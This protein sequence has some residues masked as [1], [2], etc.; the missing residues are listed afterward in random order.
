VNCNE[1]RKSVKRDLKK[2]K[3]TTKEGRRQLDAE[4]DVLSCSGAR[5]QTITMLFSYQAQKDKT[6]TKRTGKD[7]SP[8]L[9]KKKTGM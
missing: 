6:R 7:R 1:K 2:K 4:V 8:I 3:L 5:D 9:G